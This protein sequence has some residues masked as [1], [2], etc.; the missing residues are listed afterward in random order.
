MKKHKYLIEY[1]KI[2]RGLLSERLYRRKNSRN[3][4]VHIK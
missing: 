3:S 4:K 1:P 2:R